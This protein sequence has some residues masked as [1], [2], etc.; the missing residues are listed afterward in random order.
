MEDHDNARAIDEQQPPLAIAAQRGLVY[1]GTKSDRMIARIP[2]APTAMLPAVTP[3]VE[4]HPDEP[5]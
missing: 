1:S 5:R 3:T 2:R 4:G